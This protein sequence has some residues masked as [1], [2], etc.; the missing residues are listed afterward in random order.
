MFE[1]DSSINMSGKG[2]KINKAHSQVDQEGLI[3]KI[4]AVFSIAAK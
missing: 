1:N 3:L 2:K 4:A